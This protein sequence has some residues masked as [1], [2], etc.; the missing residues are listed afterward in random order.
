MDGDYSPGAL[1]HELQ[2]ER[3]RRQGAPGFWD[4]PHRDEAGTADTSNYDRGTAPEELRVVAAKLAETSVSGFTRLAWDIRTVPPT[5]APVF[6]IMVALDADFAEKPF[7][8][9]MYVGY[10]GSS[11]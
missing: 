1:D 6:A 4:H 5:I 9:C 11:W 3:A 10:L 7:V 2:K 8:C